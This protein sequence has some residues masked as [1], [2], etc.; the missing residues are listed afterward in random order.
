MWNEIEFIRSVKFQIL[1]H[2]KCEM[3]P[4]TCVWCTYQSRIDVK[5]IYVK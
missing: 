2:V 3:S 5:Y 4:T 1:V